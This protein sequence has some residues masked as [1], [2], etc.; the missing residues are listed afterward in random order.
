MEQSHVNNSHPKNLD[1]S[2]TEILRQLKDK[3]L[4][5]INP[6]RK[7]GLI[8]YKRYHA[9]FAGPGAMI[10]SVIDLDAVKVLPTNRLSLVQ[11]ENSEQKVSAYLIRR[12][13]IRLIKHIADNPIPSQRAQVILNQFEHWF[14]PETTAQLPDEAFAMLVGVLPQTIKKARNKVDRLEL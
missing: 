12:Q 4:L 2:N 13:W 9:E 1:S 10:G 11:P 6:Q 8:I 7:N 3:K 14:D 5:I